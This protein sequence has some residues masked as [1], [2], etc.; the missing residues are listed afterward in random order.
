LHTHHVTACRK[1]SEGGSSKHVDQHLAANAPPPVWWWGGGSRGIV[2]MIRSNTD[3][4]DYARQLLEYLDGLKNA[5]AD[6]EGTHY[7]F[8]ASTL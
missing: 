2:P 1:L 8:T 7:S 3:A 4:R 6:R 5:E